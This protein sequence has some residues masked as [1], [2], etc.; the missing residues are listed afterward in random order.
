MRAPGEARRAA[1][2]GRGIPLAAIALACLGVSEA[3][4]QTV[5]IYASSSNA[6]ASRVLADL[7]RCT[8][9]F[10]DVLVHDLRRAT[11]TLLDLQQHHAVLVWGDQPMAD[12]D[13]F[14]DVLADYRERGGGVVVSLGAFSPD[15]G[16]GGRFGARDLPVLR[17]RVVAGGAN[18]SLAAD[19]A[20][21]WAP[22]VTGHFTTDGVNAFDGGT[23]SF[24]VDTDPA[25]ATDVV[26]VR[27]VDGEPAL[28][29]READPIT[30]GRVAAVNVHPLSEALLAGS[31]LEDVGGV[32]SDADRLFANA[33]LWSL[34]Y[35]R[36][37]STC[38]NEW[39]AYDLNCNTF[40]A[41][42][43]RPTDRANA[44]CM[45]RIDPETGAAYANDDFYYSPVTLFCENWLA[46]DD[47]DGDGLVGLVDDQ[48]TLDPIGDGNCDG[49]VDAAADQF[50]EILNTLPAPLDLSGFTLR[51]GGA[52]VHD[53]GPGPVE[54]P[55]GGAVVVFGG[56]APS[57]GL[58]LQPYEI[59]RAHV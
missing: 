44:V 50:V 40:D 57:Q 11:P 51:V 38:T 12:P 16:V 49:V 39:A 10:E 37:D 46:L 22:G 58:G 43:E 33:L 27:W 25:E 4:A 45:G 52:V 13:A 55:S 21:A 31:W 15:T 23:S 54:L 18:L 32:P 36:P 41:S 26:T 3:H 29:L 34:G 7:L 56:G 9:E 48:T 53:F 30:E 1:A 19:P 42:R 8:G 5:G 59:G 47:L 6:G 35:E 28:V 24:R 2:R 17:G 14:G 20:H